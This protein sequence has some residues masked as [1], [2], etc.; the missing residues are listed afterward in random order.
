[1]YVYNYNDEDLEI[2]N[3]ETGQISVASFTHSDNELGAETSLK[4]NFD[5]QSF[6]P[7]GMNA[8][9]TLPSNINIYRGWKE[10]TVN[11]IK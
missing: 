5:T 10:V 6:I 1:M 9:I 4:I 11:G 8:V 2:R 7:E 3:S